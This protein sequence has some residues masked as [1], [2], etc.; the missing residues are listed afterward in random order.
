MRFSSNGALLALAV[1]AVAQTPVPTAVHN[2]VLMVVAS[3]L[4]KESVSYVLTSPA[5]FAS[6]MASSF[7]AGNTPTWYQALPTDVKALLPSLY[8][9]VSSPTPTPSSSLAVDSSVGTV[10]ANPTG[11]NSTNVSE[12]HMPTLISTSARPSLPVAS[13]NTAAYPAAALGAGV[14]AALGFIGMLVL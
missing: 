4:P 11:A 3:A 1:G 10:S 5:A 2:S 7:A 13:A 6:E 8:P 9:V 12:I 14:G